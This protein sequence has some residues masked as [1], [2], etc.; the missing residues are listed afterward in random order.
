MKLKINKLLAWLLPSGCE[1]C[2]R[3]LDEGRLCQ[4]CRN[5]L[6]KTRPCCERCQAALALDGVCGECISLQPAFDKV[7]VLGDYQGSLAE[8]ITGL[9]FQGKL[10]YGRALSDLWCEALPDLYRTDEWPSLIIPV[11]LH[12]KRLRQRGFNQSLEIAK[13]IAKRFKLS[14]D[15]FSCIRIKETKPQLSLPQKERQ[16]NVAGAFATRNTLK[17]QHAVI[18]DDVFTTGHTANALAKLLKQQGIQRI[19]LWCCA[20]TQWKTP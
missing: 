10:H 4:T 16:Q 14:L 6:I 7:Y 15:K 18:I 11:P 3:K 13:P 2:H 9:K 12:Q 8:L 1:L 19:D 5:T 20:R 17:V